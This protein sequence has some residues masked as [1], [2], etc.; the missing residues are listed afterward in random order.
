MPL[1]MGGFLFAIDD[2]GSGYSSLNFLFECPADIVK[3]D[4]TLTHKLIGSILN[5]RL[6]KTIIFG[7]HEAGKKICIEGIETD[8]EMKLIDEMD[9]D[10]LQG[11][12]FYKPISPEKLISLLNR[13]SEEKE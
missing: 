4:R 10:F 7:C 13:Q 3:M 9:F 5:Y 6:L 1:G 2:L 8:E 12:Y 11:F